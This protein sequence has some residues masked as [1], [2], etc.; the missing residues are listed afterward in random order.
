MDNIKRFQ[1]PVSP[2]ALDENCIRG[3]A[4][5]FTI[6]TNCLIRMEYDP[7]G[8]FEDRASQTVFHRDLPACAYTVS[9]K[10]G[11]LTVISGRSGVFCRYFVGQTVIG[12]FLPVAIWRTL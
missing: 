5:R 2:V 6:L 9:R 4:Y 3:K 7:A 11:I 10:D 1:W 12:A 8:V